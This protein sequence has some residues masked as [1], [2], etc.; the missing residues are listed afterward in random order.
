[1]LCWDQVLRDLEGPSSNSIAP[2]LARVRS[3]A[4]ATSEAGPGAAETGAAG[5]GPGP[6]SGE[7]VQQ[8]T[9]AAV[10]LLG[11]GSMPGANAH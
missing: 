8:L 6:G 11:G 2:P 7:L 5:P 10:G 1:M 3:E 4:A 9:D